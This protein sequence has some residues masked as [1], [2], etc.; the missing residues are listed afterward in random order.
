MKEAVES[1]R[2]RDIEV[3]ADEASR[4]IDNHFSPDLRKKFALSRFC[5]FKTN[6]PTLAFSRLKEASLPDH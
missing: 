2:L 4:V 3:A 1:Y 6:V 5:E